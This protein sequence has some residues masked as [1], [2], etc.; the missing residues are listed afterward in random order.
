MCILDIIR[1][2]MCVS[3]QICQEKCE[4]KAKL[5]FTDMDSLT[6]VTETSYLYNHLEKLRKCLMIMAIGLNEL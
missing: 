2:L 1:M 4:N 5:L 3:L 6:F